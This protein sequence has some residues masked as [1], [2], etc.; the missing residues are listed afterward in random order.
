MSVTEITTHVDDAKARLVQQYKNKSRIAGI[1][2][3]LVDQIQELETVGKELNDERSVSASIGVQLDKIGEIVGITRLGGESDALYRARINARISLNVSEG[4]PERLISTFILLIGA[5]SVLLQELP[6]ADVA[7][8]SATDFADQDE[9]DAALAILESVA[10]AGVRINYIGVYDSTEPF[11]MAGGLSGL[12]FSSLASPTTGGK[13]S[14]IVRRNS[15]FSFAG[16]EELKNE[17]FG[18]IK[19]TH[20]GGLMDKL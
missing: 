12:G 8:S 2:K 7:I 6:P 11:A 15:F 13:F 19:D 20:V 17:G 5:D 9:V 3:A 1:L 16:N 10:P 14:K 4:E 18:T